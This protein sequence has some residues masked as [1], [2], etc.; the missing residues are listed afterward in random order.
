MALYFASNS[1]ADGPSSLLL[2]LAVVVAACNP[3]RNLATAF[4]S[5]GRTKDLAK[6]W[7]SG[8]YRVSPLGTSMDRLKWGF[9]SL[10]PPQEKEFVFLEA[11]SA[12]VGYCVYTIELFGR[13]MFVHESKE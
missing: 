4:S 3:C 8:H 9:G 10:T 12:L 6:E 7:A 13:T 1:D 11:G 5:D 2:P